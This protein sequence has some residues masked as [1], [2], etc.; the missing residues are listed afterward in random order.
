MRHHRDARDGVALKVVRKNG[1]PK[2]AEAA[3]TRACV[4][5]GAAGRAGALYRELA[6]WELGRIHLAFAVALAI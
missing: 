3:G 5:R 4:L 1:T 6:F 2:P